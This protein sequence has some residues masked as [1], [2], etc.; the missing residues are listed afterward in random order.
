MDGKKENIF[1]MD[2]VLKAL[3]YRTYKDEN[4]LEE[5]L[6]ALE[7]V[8]YGKS[9]GDSLSFAIK[10]ADKYLED[11]SER[12][13]TMDK[14]RD[15]SNA[16]TKHQPGYFLKSEGNRRELPR[17]RGVAELKKY[18]KIVAVS[19]L[20][21][22]QDSPTNSYLKK[23][24]LN[25]VGSS[26]IHHL[27]P[28][29]KFI[30]KRTNSLA[31]SLDS[32][33]GSARSSYE[34]NRRKAF[35]QRASNRQPKDSMKTSQEG[36]SLRRTQS[37]IDRIGSKNSSEGLEL[38][39]EL[40]IPEE[41]ILKF[42]TSKET[43]MRQK[44]Q[45]TDI[46]ARLFVIH[47]TDANESNFLKNP[48]TGDISKIDNANASLSKHMVPFS[49]PNY[50][51]LQ[52]VV[53]LGDFIL[54]EKRERVYISAKTDRF[55]MA[56]KLNKNLI[57]NVTY[58]D[59][60]HDQSPEGREKLFLLTIFTKRIKNMIEMDEKVRGY[61]FSDK[62][63]G[64]LYHEL[65]DADKK[66]ASDYLKVLKKNYQKRMDNV[67]DFMKIPLCKLGE[68]EHKC[69]DYGYEIPNMDVDY[70]LARRAIQFTSKKGFTLHE[71][72][73]MSHNPNFNL[74]PTD[75]LHNTKN[76]PTILKTKEKMD[77]KIKNFDL[78]L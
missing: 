74:E 30:I 10:K 72:K 13:E 68:L 31:S 45:M 20:S 27:L 66:I 11:A 24:D 21:F 65:S 56:Q 36:R 62:I 55:Q 6:E 16:K 61:I 18:L 49:V 35:Y 22:S 28:K 1:K 26:N 77:E 67:E 71:F 69:R 52:S 60:I 9:L 59:L 73:N 63:L 78:K 48:A 29:E 34:T 14:P 51:D 38:N 32:P 70:S 33:D 8:K 54:K 76:S 43:T 4:E 25:D 47:E 17:F 75:L 46:L 5:K 57:N 2:P 58:Q 44:L 23:E 64:D 39:S 40:A 7:K 50:E 19:I 15:Y 3:S 53:F 37:K 42:Y 12:S 41:G